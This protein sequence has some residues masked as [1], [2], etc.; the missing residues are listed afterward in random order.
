M[1]RM[2]Q[3]GNLEEEEVVEEMEEKEKY[4]AI[5]EDG[6]PW[7]AV[8]KKQEIRREDSKKP[9][10]QQG[11]AEEVDEEKEYLA[12]GEDGRPYIA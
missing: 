5:G 7:I 6:R 2:E 12:I 9:V 8:R 4:L 11:V 10:S 3:L 1:R